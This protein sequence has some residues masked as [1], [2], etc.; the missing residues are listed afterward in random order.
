MNIPPQVIAKS[1]EQGTFL[2]MKQTLTENDVKHQYEVSRNTIIKWRNDGLP[3]IKCGNKT[4][5]R[6]S[7]IEAFLD[8]YEI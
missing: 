4:Y 2:A 3:V 8:K 6:R 7:D 5:Y 1:I